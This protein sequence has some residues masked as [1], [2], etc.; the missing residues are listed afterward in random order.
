[1]LRDDKIERAEMRREIR[2]KEQAVTQKR[3]VST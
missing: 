3:D 1:M 2:R